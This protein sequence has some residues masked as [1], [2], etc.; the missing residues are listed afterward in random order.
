MR[1]MRLHT[2]VR[3]VFSLWG[4]GIRSVSW[5]RRGKRFSILMIRLVWFRGACQEMWSRVWDLS[6]GLE[7]GRF[8]EVVKTYAGRG[9]GRYCLLTV[10]SP[11]QSTIYSVRLVSQ[12][13]QEQFRARILETH[14]KLCLEYM[15]LLVSR[16][17]ATFVS[18]AR[19]VAAVNRFLSIGKILLS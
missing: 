9:C 10:S 16:R 3:I 5:I 19:F 17:M 13:L 12:L 4:M 14:F 2:G 7:M 18:M 15:F 1:I 11:L 6:L 8:W